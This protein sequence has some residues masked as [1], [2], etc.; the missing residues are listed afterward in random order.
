[1]RDLNFFEPFHEKRQ[2]KFNR[3]I[4]LYTLLAISLI[5]I[6][7]L[8]LMNYVQIKALNNEVASLRE[9]AD[10]PETMQKVQEIKEFEEQTNQFRDEVNR[11]KQLDRSIQARDI[12]GE[13]LLTDV[14]SKLPE[15]VF[16]TNLDLN[17]KSV[18]ISGAAE[19][20]YSVA[21]FAK[22]LSQLMDVSE[23]F[24]SNISEVE[25]YYTF[26]MD[27]TLREALA[28]GN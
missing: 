2:F 15:G 1:M 27:V 23:V 14:N 21:E 7:G 9:V 3:M 6:I 8:A 17:G 24:I 25:S 28:D 20:K 16:V 13:R 11:I 10:N 26:T 18:G 4:L 22:G 5:T 12:V 19:D